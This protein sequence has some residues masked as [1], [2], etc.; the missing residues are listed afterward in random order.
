MALMDSSLNAGCVAKDYSYQKAAGAAVEKV[1]RMSESMIPTVLTM[2][3]R[4]FV[5]KAQKP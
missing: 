1:K 2:S 5:A 4:T 3:I